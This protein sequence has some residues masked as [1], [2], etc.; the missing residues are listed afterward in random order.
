MQMLE[1]QPDGT[2]ATIADAVPLPADAR[3][4]EQWS[5]AAAGPGTGAAVL[6]AAALAACG[7]GGG[8][9]VPPP[10]GPPPSGVDASRFLTQAS[11]GLRDVGEVSALQAQGFEAWLSRQFGLPAASHVSYLEAWAARRGRNQPVEEAS[12]EAIWQ[13]WLTGEDQLRGRVSWA[14]LQIFVISNIA[15]DIRPFAMSSYMDML[16]RN[17]FGN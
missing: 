1:E 11:F 13:Q 12:Y 15:P 17:A 5:R 3:A 14:L 8:A 2:A 7:G 6:S 16:N 9:E 4:A 10:A